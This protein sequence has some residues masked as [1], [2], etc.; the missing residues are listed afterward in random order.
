MKKL[1]LACSVTES[2]LK[3]FLLLKFSAELFHECEWFLSCDEFCFNF[4]E[5]EY[6]NCN[7]ANLNLQNGKVFGN[8]EEINNFYGV[9][10]G[11]FKAVEA[12]IQTRGE[13]LL[14]DSDI[15][16]CGEFEG[17]MPD[18]QAAVCPHYQWDSNM[19]QA[20]G[21]YN[22]GFVY[23]SDI[24]FLNA[25]MTETNLQGNEFEQVPI[26]RV[27]ESGVFKVQI[28]PICHNMGWWRF[29]SRAKEHRVYS[30][31]TRNN[32]ILFDGNLVSSFHFH[33]FINCYHSEPFMEVV[34]EYLFQ[35]TEIGKE[36]L[37]E[38]NRLLLWS[39]Y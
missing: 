18:A 6:D 29:N 26:Q 36:I 37:K 3:E 16:F 9:I 34:F 15:I 14:V 4:L 5:R 24:A 33:T 20:W 7:C 38:Y 17:I 1:T 22:V 8:E 19:D 11:K 32:R 25:W 2:H 13:C 21:K 35:A 39:A 12:A 28:L 10:D 27:V 23:I 30:F 31:E